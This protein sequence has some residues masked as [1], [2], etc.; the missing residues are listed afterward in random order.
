MDLEFHVLIRNLLRWT[1]LVHYFH[2]NG[3]PAE[4][5]F[6]GIIEQAKEV[7]TVQRNLR[8]Y[9]WERYSARQEQHINMGGFVGE[10][11]F[12]GDLWPFMPLIKAGEVLH[13]GKGTAFG[14]GRYEVK[15][16]FPVEAREA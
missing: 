10:I 4:F 5:D 8:W 15:H 7:R 9:G 3:K 14:L 16:Q 13:V 2:G 6:K 12:E 11:T 1:S